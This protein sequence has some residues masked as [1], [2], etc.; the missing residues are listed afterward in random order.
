MWV[1]SSRN[2]GSPP[3]RISIGVGLTAS[4]WSTMPRHAAVSSS[5]WRFRGGPPR[6]SSGRTPDYSAASGSTPRRGGRSSLEQFLDRLLCLVG[7]RAFEVDRA[8]THLLLDVADRAARDPLCLR[9]L[10]E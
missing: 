4:T 10:D 1:R 8:L 6:C 5:R 2:S 7:R 3:E 9:L